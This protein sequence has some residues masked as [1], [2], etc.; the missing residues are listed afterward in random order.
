MAVRGTVW[1][2]TDKHGKKIIGDDRHWRLNVAAASRVDRDERN[3]RVTATLADIWQTEL[4]FPPMGI[5]VRVGIEAE[6]ELQILGCGW[7][8]VTCQ[9]RGDKVLLHHNGNKATMK[10]AAFKAL[11]AANKR[12]RGKRPRLRLAVSNSSPQTDERRAA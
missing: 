8:I 1:L 4:N 11:L 2:A 6:K 3:K 12:V 7:R 10:R 9:F 5:R